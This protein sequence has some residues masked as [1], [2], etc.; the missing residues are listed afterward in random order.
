MQIAI[1]LE[2]EFEVD[3]VDNMEKPQRTMFK[4]A[5]LSLIGIESSIVRPI[6]TANHFE[7]K[8]SII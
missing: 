4:Y 5:R 2:L 6:V 3:Q 8:M 1:K 7:I